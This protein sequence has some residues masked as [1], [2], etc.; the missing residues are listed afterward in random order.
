MIEFIK[1]EEITQELNDLLNSS[2]NFYHKLDWIN[3]LKSIGTNPE[4]Y[5][6]KEGEEYI[7]FF[8]IIFSRRK[9]TSYGYIPAGI[10]F[11]K[12]R[13]IYVD[14]K[15]FLETLAKLK[16]VNAI[17]FDSPINIE[18]Y[19]FSKSLAPGLPEYSSELD[20]T[21]N[22]DEIRHNLSKSTRYNINKCEKSGISIKKWNSEKEVEDFYSIMNQTEQRKSFKN[23]NKDYF[24]KQFELLKDSVSEMYLA[25]FNDKPIAGA[26]VNLG[27]NI[28]Y[29]THG[30]STS[31][32]ELS[33]L[34]SPYFLQ[35]KIINDLKERG[36]EKY[37]LWGVIPDNLKKHPLK[38]VSDFKKSFGG[39]TLKREGVFEVY[40]GLFPSLMTK[41]YDFI[42]YK[43]DRF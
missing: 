9:L 39:V 7:A 14:L 36:F 28:A 33:K 42:V 38:G 35:W 17:R 34:R 2:K 41:V 20:L 29:Y 32:S 5:C 26:I 18:K 6:V 3:F 13:D 4:V 10:R 8:Y 12:E 40:T 22:I 16:S 19:G 24:L 31:D 37:N 1:I 27:S 25:Y 30:A 11:F 43:N 21:K 23:F 15:I